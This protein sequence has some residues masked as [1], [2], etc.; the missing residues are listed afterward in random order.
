VSND[1]VVRFAFESNSNNEVV[2]WSV[3][4]GMLS[5]GTPGAREYYQPNQLFKTKTKDESQNE[6]IEYKDKQG[7]VVLKKVQAPN[8]EWAQTYYV[9]DDFGNLSIVLSPEAVKA[10]N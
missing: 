2:L 4:N 6:V 7:R 1:H 5:S 8:S 9:Y 10:L 3:S